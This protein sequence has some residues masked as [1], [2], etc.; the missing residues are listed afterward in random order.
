M[1]RQEHFS[2]DLGRESLA[3]LRRIM[4]VAL[5]GCFCRVRRSEVRRDS[6]LRCDMGAQVLTFFC[7]MGENLVL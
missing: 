6:R 2:T 3:R 7:S 4:M 1:C 5:G